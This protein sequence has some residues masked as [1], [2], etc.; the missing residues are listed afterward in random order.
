VSGSE[1]KRYVQAQSGLTFA[2][3]S[4]NKQDLPLLPIVVLNMDSVARLQTLLIDLSVAAVLF[5]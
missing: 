4:M 1:S 2:V 3:G 5:V